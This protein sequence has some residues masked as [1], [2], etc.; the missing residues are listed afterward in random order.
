MERRINV[1]SNIIEE[2]KDLKFYIAALPAQ[3]EKLQEITIGV[4]KDYEVFDRFCY[5]IPD[6]DVSAK[7]NTAIYSGTVMRMGKSAV[8]WLIDDYDKSLEL[9][10]VQLNQLS[11]ELE[12]LTNSVMELSEFIDLEQAVNVCKHINKLKKKEQKLTEQSTLLNRRQRIFGCDPLFEEELKNV[13]AGIQ[14][15]DD[16]W[17]TCLGMIL[18][19]VFS[20]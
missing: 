17:F 16:L 3:I 14:P 9:Q 8:T 10:Q 7:W 6:E 12:I 15:Y 11:D 20:T 13:G 19:H 2:V 5:T 1:R 18:K 4:I